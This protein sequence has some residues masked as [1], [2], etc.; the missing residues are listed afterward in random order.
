MSRI[1]TPEEIRQRDAAKAAEAA[2]VKE[3]ADNAAMDKAAAEKEAAE[4]A[5]AARAAAENAAANKLAADQ[6]AAQAARS[7]AAR[8]AAAHRLL[9]RPQQAAAS[10]ANNVKPP[11]PWGESTAPPVEKKVEKIEAPKGQEP[12]Y[13]VFMPPLSFDAK[14][15]APADNFDPKF[16][17]LVRRV[18][19]KPTLIFKGTVEGDTPAAKQV[20]D[21]RPVSTTAKVGP[22]QPPNAA[23]PQGTQSNAKP[24]PPANDSVVNRVRNYLR[25]LFS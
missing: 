23:T 25:H 6:A 10:A 20:S 7:A 2:A 19:V 9:H 15:A 3:A 8:G 16:I 24:A 21:V 17:M 1:A 13:Q 4:R 22:V 12:V 11:V 18:R 5:A 14:A